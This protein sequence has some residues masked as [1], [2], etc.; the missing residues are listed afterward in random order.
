MK[1]YIIIIAGIPASGKTTY[2]QYIAERLH[3]PF[4]G[5]DAIKEKLY[6]ILNYDTTKRE[7]SA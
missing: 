2:A 3:I 1:P 6:D 7:K 5:K 4:I